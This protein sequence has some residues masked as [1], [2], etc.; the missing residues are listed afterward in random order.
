MV[1]TAQVKGQVKGGVTGIGGT[2]SSCSLALLI[3]IANVV[4]STEPLRCT[5]ILIMWLNPCT[6]IKCML[7]RT[8]N[9]I[10]WLDFLLFWPHKVLMFLS[11]LQDCNSAWEVG[12]NYSFTLMAHFHSIGDVNPPVCSCMHAGWFFFT[13]ARTVCQPRSAGS[14]STQGFILITERGDAAARDGDTVQTSRREMK[15]N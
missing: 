10:P 9:F 3:L 12:L 14:F 7:A 2:C 4:G 1:R 13:R 5:C 6:Q 11:W 8:N 15:I